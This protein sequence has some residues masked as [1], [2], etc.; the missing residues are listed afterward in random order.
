M[1]I[2]ASFLH[3]LHQSSLLLNCNIVFLSL[4]KLENGNHL[5]EDNRIDVMHLLALIILSIFLLDD[6]IFIM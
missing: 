1:S 5:V 4:Q 3:F 6:V 2:F